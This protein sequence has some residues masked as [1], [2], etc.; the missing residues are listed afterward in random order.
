MNLGTNIRLW[1]PS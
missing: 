1:R